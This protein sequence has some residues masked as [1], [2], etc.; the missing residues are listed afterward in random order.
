[1]SK[2]TPLFVENDLN[3]LPV[4]TR[5]TVEIHDGRIAVVINNDYLNII[6]FRNR[7]QAALQKV[8]HIL[9]RDYD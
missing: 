2:S 4:C 7:I 6:A 1:M 3:I 8:G 9:M 5:K